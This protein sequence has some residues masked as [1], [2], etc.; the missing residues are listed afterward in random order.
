MLTLQQA[1]RSEGLVLARHKAHMYL[2]GDN[3]TRVYADE[4]AAVLA[5]VYEDDELHILIDIQ[6]VI[7]AQWW[8]QVKALQ[9]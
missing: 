7:E 8:N 1:I 5:R 9:K 6:Q 4:Q 2:G 3:D